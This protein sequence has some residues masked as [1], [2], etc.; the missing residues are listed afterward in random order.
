MVKLLFFGTASLSTA[1]LENLYS[2][3]HDIFCVTMPDKPASRGQQLSAPATKTFA[4]NNG[5]PFIQPEKYDDCVFETLKSFNADA[6]I[7]VSYGK[8]IPERIFLLPKHKTFNIHFSLLPKYRGAAP[9]QYALLN[10]ESETGVSSFYLEKTLDT[11]DILIQKKA[12][13]EPSD[14]A[15]SLF[16]KLVP[17]GID[18]MNETLFMFQNGLISGKK[19]EGA[20]SYAHILKKED[21]LIKWEKSAGE[22]LNMF[23]GLYTWP[24][25]YCVVSTGALAGKRIKILELETLENASLNGDFGRVFAIEK[26]K[27]FSVLCAKGKILITKVQP[28]NRPAM[29]A[30]D[31]INGGRLSCGDYL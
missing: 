7:A 31:F 6:A 14:T 5:I 11:G 3:K 27:G 2:A 21:G 8:L 10:G 25:T 9:V 22:I 18:V 20:P 12:P 1:F 23:R 15:E 19:Q 28:E 24:G 29:T 17:L 30:W 16:S 4:V 26:N 13:I